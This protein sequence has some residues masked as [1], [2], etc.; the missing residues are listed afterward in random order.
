MR[1]AGADVVEGQE[2]GTERVRQD[3]KC[4]GGE[5]VRAGAGA[6]RV[7]RGRQAEVR[8]ERGAAE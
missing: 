4:S 6:R 1:A 8:R 7:A 2:V 3:Q 5:A